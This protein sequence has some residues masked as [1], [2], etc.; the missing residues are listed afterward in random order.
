M[1]RAELEQ[2]V[3]RE[4]AA[5]LQRD[6]AS[7]RPDDLLAGDLGAE[8]IDLIDLTFRLERALEIEIPQGE[9]FEGSSPPPDQLRVH[10]VLDYLAARRAGP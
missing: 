7:I 6:A 3:L 10:D 1:N 9:L 2:T 4:I 5:C 8:S